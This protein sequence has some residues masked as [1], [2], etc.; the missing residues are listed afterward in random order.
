[1]EAKILE[2]VT[3]LQNI[4]PVLLEGSGPEPIPSGAQISPEPLKMTWFGF[5]S[6]HVLIELASSS[7][8]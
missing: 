7:C 3:L 2:T 6:S 8:V 5:G 4:S 1:L